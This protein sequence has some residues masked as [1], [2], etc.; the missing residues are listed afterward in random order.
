MTSRLTD[1]R[2][3]AA[4]RIA[5]TGDG[6]TQADTPPDGEVL[7]RE[8]GDE[9]RLTPDGWLAYVNRGKGCV[10]VARVR[11]TEAWVAELKAAAES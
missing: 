6:W 8:D 9:V 10:Y 7:W 2:W 3:R 1:P 5:A 11:A 4:Q